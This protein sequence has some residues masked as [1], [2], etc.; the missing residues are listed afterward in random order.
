[1]RSKASLVYRMTQYKKE[2]KT[3]NE[4]PLSRVSPVQYSLR[5]QSFEIHY[6]YFSEQKLTISSVQFMSLT[7]QNNETSSAV[8]ATRSERAVS[9]SN[10]VCLN[11]RGSGLLVF[12][13]LGWLFVNL[14]RRRR[15][16]F[17]V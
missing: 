17:A 11:H 16:F 12:E 8:N 13:V 15:L 7:L 1:M 14:R 10:P 3:K 2:E 4:K 9:Y 5:R 6:I